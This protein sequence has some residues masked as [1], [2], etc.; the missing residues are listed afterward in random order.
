M[1]VNRDW[2]DLDV[3]PKKNAREKEIDFPYDIG[4]WLLAAVSVCNELKICLWQ[5]VV[6]AHPD[7]KETNEEREMESQRKEE[8]R[9]SLNQGSAN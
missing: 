2:S 3:L 4:L 6:W 1:P 8:S 5:Q 7:E 9:T